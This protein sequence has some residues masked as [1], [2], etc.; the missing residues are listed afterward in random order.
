MFVGKQDAK[1]PSGWKT[2]SSVIFKEVS[3][4]CY[5][6]YYMVALARCILVVIVLQ[7]LQAGQYKLAYRRLDFM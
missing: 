4:Q 1:L 5:H 2:F 3:S 7:F 6:L